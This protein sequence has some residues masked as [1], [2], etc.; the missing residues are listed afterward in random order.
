MP[1]AIKI[2]AY[3][4]EKTFTALGTDGF[5]RSD[6]REQLRK[7]FEVNRYHVAIAALSALVKEGALE[8]DKVSEAITKYEVDTEAP[9]PWTI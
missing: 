3:I 8:E 7:H 1:G 6:T 9:A 5:G 4:P 2:R